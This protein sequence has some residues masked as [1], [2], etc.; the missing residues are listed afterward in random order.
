MVLDGAGTVTTLV[1]SAESLT[2]LLTG[3]VADPAAVRTAELDRRAL[4][5]DASHILLVPSAIVAPRDADEVARLLRATSAAGIA[6]TFRSGGTSLSGQAG[7]EGVLADVR[8]NFQAVEVLDSGA[9]VR[10]SPG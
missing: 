8:R 10:V 9:R 4:A 6:L 5:H 7:T 3:C 2:T 1:Q